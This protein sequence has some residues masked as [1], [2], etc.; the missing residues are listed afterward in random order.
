MKTIFFTIVAFFGIAFASQAQKYAYI[1]S[2]YILENIP[3]YA[4]AKEKLD[5]YAERWQKEID[6]RYE[7]LDK[8][9]NAFNKEEVLLPDDVRAQR[10]AEIDTMLNQ[11]MALQKMHFGVGGDLFQKRQELIKPIQDAIFDAL[12]KVASRGN[13]SFVFDKANQSNLIFAD[14][15]YDISERV[16]KEMDINK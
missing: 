16:L 7:A 9:R 10:K 15:K 11:A 12:A 5:K 3:A 2:K 4:E 1:D 6:A 13:Y 14:S 8:M